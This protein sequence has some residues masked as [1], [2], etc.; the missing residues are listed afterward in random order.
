MYFCL[1]QRTAGSVGLERLTQRK[2][3]QLI[4]GFVCN[5]LILIIASLG[6]AIHVEECY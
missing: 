1:S 4:E 2:S 3:K 5:P 6:L